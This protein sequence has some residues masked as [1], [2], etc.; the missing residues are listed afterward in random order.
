METLLLLPLV[1]FCCRF[2]SGSAAELGV[3]LLIPVSADEVDLVDAGR[4]D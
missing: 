4:M 1:V 2:R 3:F